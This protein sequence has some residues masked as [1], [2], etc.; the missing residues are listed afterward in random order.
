L[1][2]LPLASQEVSIS[3][4][5]KEINANGADKGRLTELARQKNICAHP[6]FVRNV[7]VDFRPKTRNS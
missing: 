6:I 1:K 4:E 2:N 7:R 3:A 5:E